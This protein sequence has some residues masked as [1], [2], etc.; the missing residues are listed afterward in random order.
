MTSDQEYYIN[1]I[2]KGDSKGLRKIYT[3]FLPRITNF[4]RSKGGSSD[5]AEDI[6]QN[7][8]LLIYEKSKKKDFKLTSNFYTLLYGIC[9]NLWGNKIQKKSNQE[10]SIPEDAKYSTEENIE[11]DM[12][13]SEE[14][15]LFWAAFELLGEDCQR[16][17]RLFFEKTKMEEIAEKMGFSSV[18][19][20]K[21]RKFQCKEK[22]V[23]FVRSDIRFPELRKSH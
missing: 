20:A 12:E 6:F 14:Q 19:Y 3:D 13:R 18:S 17:L 21:K 4:I 8:L 23:E 1:A 11:N 22:L 16:L 2:K 5:D 10:V 7:A 15:A 9:W